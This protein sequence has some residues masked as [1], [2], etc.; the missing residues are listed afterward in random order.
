MNSLRTPDQ[1]PKWSKLIYFFDGGTGRP[2]AVSP[3][4]ENILLITVHFD[5][6]TPIPP[7]ERGFRK[8]VLTDRSDSTR[9]V[10]NCLGVFLVANLDFAKT[11]VVCGKLEPVDFITSEKKNVFL[12]YR[13]PS[14]NRGSVAS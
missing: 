7:C 5:D 3:R 9:G 6:S 11:C 2:T 12:C 8:K 4:K 13:F 1:N 14:L 10:L